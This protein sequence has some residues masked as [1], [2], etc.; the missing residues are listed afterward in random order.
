MNGSN[1]R[2]LG[3]EPVD[4]AASPAIRDTHPTVG[5]LTLWDGGRGPEPP[6]ERPQQ[7]DRARLAGTVSHICE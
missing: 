3:R 7:P 2:S 6:S 1:R 4:A 5:R